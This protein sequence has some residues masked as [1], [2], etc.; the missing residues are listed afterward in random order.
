[1][2]ATVEAQVEADHTELA[3]ES[4]KMLIPLAAVVGEAGGGAYVWKIPKT[5]GH[6]VKTSVEIG[7]VRRGGIEIFSGLETGELVAV[8]GVHSLR[9]DLLVRPA[10]P[11]REGLDQ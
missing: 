10:H 7:E 4:K 9:T 11:D 5:G 2:T 6:P 1:M 3:G 8:A